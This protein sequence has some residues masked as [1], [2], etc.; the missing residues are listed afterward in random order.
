MKCGEV[1]WHREATQ[2]CFQY[3]GYVPVFYREAGDSAEAAE[4][5]GVLHVEPPYGEPGWMTARL[6]NETRLMKIQIVPAE[7]ASALEFATGAPSSRNVDIKGFLDLSKE[8]FPT[9]FAH[10][11]TCT[12]SL[13]VPAELEVLKLFLRREHVVEESM[14]YFCCMDD[15]DTRA[16]VRIDFADETAVDAGG[17]HH[18]TASRRGAKGDVVTVELVPNGGDILVTD[19]NKHSFAEHWLQLVPS[20]SAANSHALR[21]GRVRLRAMWLRH[22]RRG[23]L[24]A[25]YEVLEKSDGDESSSVVLGARS[26]YEPRVPPSTVAVCYRVLASADRGLPTPDQPRRSDLPVHFEGRAL[27]VHPK[28]R[29]LQPVRPAACIDSRGA[30]GGALRHP[31]HGDVRVHDSVVNSVDFFA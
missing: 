5:E 26:R 6:Q 12:S 24:G 18:F 10:F 30:Q 25:T 21:R 28:P 9:K 23:G 13:I 14:E 31:Q 1:F 7:Q 27:C 11:V 15:N 20:G 17:V 2:E 22:H 16:V 4:A 19:A 29:V 8:D 3:P